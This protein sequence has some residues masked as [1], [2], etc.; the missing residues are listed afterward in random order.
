[1]HPR[2]WNERLRQAA[3]AERLT[4]LASVR[5]GQRNALSGTAIPSGHPSRTELLA[6]GYACTED[7]PDPTGDALED[8][9]DELERA[10]LSADDAD[11]LLTYLGYDLSET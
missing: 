1:M 5:L 3:D 11:S 4:A 6:A 9:R 7:L 2:R 10:G 8:A